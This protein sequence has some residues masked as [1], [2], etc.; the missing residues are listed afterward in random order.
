MTDDRPSLCAIDYALAETERTG[1]PIRI[2]ISTHQTM[3]CRGCR[4]SVPP[5][6]WT[7]F[8]RHEHEGAWGLC[9]ECASCGECHQRVRLE[10]GVFDRDR[11]VFHRACVVMCSRCLDPYPRSRGG[12][13]LCRALAKSAAACSDEH[14][15]GMTA[16]QWFDAHLAR[17]IDP[18]SDELYVLNFHPRMFDGERFAGYA[19]WQRDLRALIAVA[20][21]GAVVG[22]GAQGLDLV[23]KHQPTLEKS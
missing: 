9:D 17:F 14:D 21:P 22:M 18:T 6:Q 4:R 1:K 3:W 13:A 7:S 20:Y 11:K 23:F 19:E 5:S 10:T 15:L 16:A 12:C 2:T 8:R